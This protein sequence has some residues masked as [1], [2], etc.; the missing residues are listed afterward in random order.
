MQLASS[1]GAGTVAQ[2]AADV[3]FTGDTPGQTTRAEFESW[4]NRLEIMAKAAGEEGLR[5][6][7]RNHAWD[8]VELDS[9][10]P[11]ELLANRFAPG[12]FDFEIDLGWAAIAGVE[13][14]ALIAQL[15]PR[16]LALHLKDVGRS[17][18]TASSRKFV[19]PGD[20]DMVYPGLFA[21]L[22][23]LTD[24]IGNIEADDPEGG[25]VTAASG[26]ETF[27]RAAQTQAQGRG[28]QVGRTS[29]LPPRSIRIGRIRIG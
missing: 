25:L 11:L 1:I 24:A 12:E 19:A 18:V 15:G 9:L 23:R 4:M 6:V 26:S 5:L 8:H 21:R 16:V 13:P 17:C 28:K 2:S 29:R 10:T 22:K 14:L 3:F 7:C 27:L 20:G